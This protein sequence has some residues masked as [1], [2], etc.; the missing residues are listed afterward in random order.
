MSVN[1]A[2]RIII[3]DS[4]M[5]LQV[6]ASLINNSRGGIYNSNMLEATDYLAVSSMKKKEEKCL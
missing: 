3:N 4:S 1:D 2:S 5:M 6:V